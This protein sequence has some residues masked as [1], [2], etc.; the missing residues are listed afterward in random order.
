MPCNASYTRFIFLDSFSYELQFDM[1]GV[2]WPDLLPSSC[3][4]GWWRSLFTAGREESQS[5]AERSANECSAL[6]PHPGGVP[7]PSEEYLSS[8]RRP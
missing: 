5:R 6:L 7:S 2:H 8:P 4:H 3:S 1:S